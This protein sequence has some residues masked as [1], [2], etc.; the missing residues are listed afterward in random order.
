M[1]DNN[2]FLT[3]SAPTTTKWSNTLCFTS[4]FNHCQ[5]HS[6]FNHFVGLVLKGLNEP[7]LWTNSLRVSRSNLFLILQTKSFAKCLY[8]YL[9]S[10][11]SGAISKIN[12]PQ[13]WPDDLGP[14][15]CKIMMKY[16]T[17]FLLPMILK[18]KQAVLLKKRQ[19]SFRAK[20]T[21]IFSL[22]K[23]KFSNTVYWFTIVLIL[24]PSWVCAYFKPFI[25]PL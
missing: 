22:R 20:C 23:G 3:L 2:L 16:L 19:I 10:S 7:P 12:K 4:V 1:I 24:R 18:K 21:M 11:F 13:E 9:G 17:C 15:I 14:V 5:T 6:A 8:H 25:I